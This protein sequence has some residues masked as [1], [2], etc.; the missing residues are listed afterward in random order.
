MAL[1]EVTWEGGGWRP[2]WTRHGLWPDDW[3]PVD[4]EPWYQH[5][6][7]LVA[8][9]RHLAE[10]EFRND[11]LGEVVVHVPTVRL[12]EITAVTGRYVI[13]LGHFTPSA[14]RPPDRLMADMMLRAVRRS[15]SAASRPAPEPRPGPG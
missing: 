10:A 13:A 9:Q 1:E 3:S 14:G 15:C 5:G 7:A 2:L 4:V 12:R 11:V 8:G 6:T